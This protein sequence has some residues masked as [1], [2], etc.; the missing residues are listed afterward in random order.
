MRPTGGA[1]LFRE[2]VATVCELLGAT[3]DT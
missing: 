1:A 2:V 3:E